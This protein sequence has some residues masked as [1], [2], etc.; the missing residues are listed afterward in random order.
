MTVSKTVRASWCILLTRHYSADQINNNWRA[1]PCSTGVVE[2][3]GIQGFGG[4]LRGRDHLEALDICRRKI[5]N[6]FWNKL[7][8]G[9]KWIDVAQ[10]TDTCVAVVN[11]VMIFI[12]HKII[13]VSWLAK[14][15]LSSEEGLCHMCLVA[16][17]VVGYLVTIQSA[18][19]LSNASTPIPP[20]FAICF[21]PFCQSVKMVPC[22][23]ILRS[24]LELTYPTTDIKYITTRTLGLATISLR[25]NVCN[26]FDSWVR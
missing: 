14:E 7:V 3:N 25:N 24:S 16:C 19:D 26:C 10:D 17:L 22:C 5:L 23:F 13:G 20:R 9:M 8:K 2:Q 21:L 12:F 6:Y 11:A 18:A 15:L 4:N 1:G